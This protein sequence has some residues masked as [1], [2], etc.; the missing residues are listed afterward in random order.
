V[1]IIEPETVVIP[2][3]QVTLGVP[4]CPEDTK[5]HRWVRMEINVPSFAIA[6]YPVTVKE[7]LAFADASGYAIS[8]QLR[9]DPRFS[10][11]RAPAVFMSWIDA[12]RYTQWLARNTGKPYRLPRDAEY[13]KA[14]RGGLTGKRYPW[15]DEPPQGR[16]D[17][18]NPEGSP[19]PVG[20]FAPNGYGLYD[21][22]GSVWSWCEECYDQVARNDKATLFYDDTLIKDPRL[23]PICRGGSF[24]SGNVTWLHCAYRHEDPVD[25][26][27]DC[28]GVRVTLGA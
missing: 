3:G 10:N 20:S 28:I 2:A 5:P 7:Y 18:A 23:N 25:G 11:P 6:K 26:R 21:M 14:S 16:A 15:G 27:Y 12:V 17:I 19:K 9:T 22:V 13:E 4:D 1:A 24:K 8:D